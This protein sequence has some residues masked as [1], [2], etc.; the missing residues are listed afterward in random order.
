MD[1]DKPS[2]ERY[3]LNIAREIAKRSTC[4]RN[5]G[6][7]IIVRDD[8]IVAAGYIGAP[9]K[10]KDCTER[11][12]CL[13][14]K[15]NVPHGQ[16]YELCRSVHAEM[17]AIINAARAGVSLF[18]GDLYNYHHERDSF[19]CFLC[20]KMII[21]AGL[22]KVICSTKDGSFKTFLVE[23]WIKEWQEKDMI[24]D[25]DQYGKDINDEN[26]SEK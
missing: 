25:K 19:A 5:K 6:G 8:Q 12:E 9:R 20:K 13:R 1:K 11:K 21:N 15:L 22:N 17:N 26:D 23:D 4:F 2:K 18:K 14:E 7:A 3:Y 24:D 10:T 16:R